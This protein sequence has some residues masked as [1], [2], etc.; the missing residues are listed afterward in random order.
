MVYDESPGSM[1]TSHHDVIVLGTGGVG[2]A[3]LWSLAR[4]GASVLGL[5]QHPI[6]HDRG[7]SHGQTRAIRK[8]YFEHPDY[9][10]LLDRAYQRWAELE[11]QSARSLF[12]R[13]GILQ[14][15]PPGGEI[16]RCQRS[17]RL[18]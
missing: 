2:S 9:V 7:S 3:A 6:A 11:E 15:G 13:V 18:S 10:P 14:V 16:P 4:A 12:A 1:S 17:C 5:D 8:A